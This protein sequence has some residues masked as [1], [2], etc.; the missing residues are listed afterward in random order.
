ML[1]IGIVKCIV[2]L[3]RYHHRKS[4]TLVNEKRVRRKNAYPFWPSQNIPTQRKKTRE[5][6]ITTLLILVLSVSETDI[7]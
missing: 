6:S 4:R 3:E 7:R 5:K 1:D 2:E